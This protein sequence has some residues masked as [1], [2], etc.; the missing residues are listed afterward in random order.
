MAIFFFFYHQLTEIKRHSHSSSS[1]LTMEPGPKGCQLTWWELQHFRLNFS[2]YKWGTGTC[3]IKKKPECN[4]GKH[5]LLKRDLE[6]FRSQD[7]VN[8]RFSTQ[9]N[10]LM[11]FILQET[12]I[13][14]GISLLFS[15]GTSLTMSSCIFP[16]KSPHWEVLYPWKC[17]HGLPGKTQDT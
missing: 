2:L 16:E 4:S 5:R 6:I 15:C 9:R 3:L 12:E 17:L 10:M 11:D 8:S 7:Q 13:F 14:S 1:A